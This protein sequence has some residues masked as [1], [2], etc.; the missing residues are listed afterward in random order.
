M[1]APSQSAPETTSAEPSL[2][3]S[4]ASFVIPK[5][6]RSTPAFTPLKVLVVD[7]EEGIRDILQDLLEENGCKVDTAS[8]GQEALRQ[9]EAKSY[10]GL[11]TDLKMPKMNGID[12]IKTIT[13]QNLCPGLQLAIVTGGI[14]FDVD[15]E[16]ENFLN[17]VTAKTFHKPFDDNEIAD[18]VNLI[19]KRD[20]TA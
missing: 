2:T 8:N 11:V 17:S 3:T 5:P 7:D 4:D 6:P 13:S 12:L 1:P 18:F 16:D 20:Q 9:L 10:D 14:T 15:S 19:R